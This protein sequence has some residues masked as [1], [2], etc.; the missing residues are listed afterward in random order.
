MIKSP[1]QQKYKIE[2]S[3]TTDFADQ[4]LFSYLVRI[5]YVMRFLYSDLGKEKQLLFRGTVT[6]V[7]QWILLQYPSELL[8]RLQFQPALPL[9][10]VPVQQPV[11]RS[12]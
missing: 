12:P 4:G 6:A 10:S 2:L 9:P 3:I 5:M 1:N 8:L 7:L 11:L